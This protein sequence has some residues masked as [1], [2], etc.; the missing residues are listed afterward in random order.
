MDHPVLPYQTSHV[1]K[2]IQW[3]FLNI[4]ASDGSFVSLPILCN[5]QIETNRH[6]VLLRNFEPPLPG[7]LDGAQTLLPFRVAC[8][9][10]AFFS[11]HDS[12]KT[13]D[14]RPPGSPSP[15]STHPP[16]S[17][18]SPHA[19]PQ[20]LSVGPDLSLPGAGAVSPAQPG[21]GPPGA[22]H[23]GAAG[24]HGERGA[25]QRRAARGRELV[26]C[27]CCKNNYFFLAGSNTGDGRISLRC[28]SHCQQ[29]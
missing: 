29:R 13:T 28:R 18:P 12:F 15:A 25:P 11:R 26:V 17:P 22:I 21:P 6:T 7:M 8:Y 16:T 9:F 3:H 2:I 4:C 27:G 19:M 1:L 14:A 24:R 10:S 23:A 20:C 5:R